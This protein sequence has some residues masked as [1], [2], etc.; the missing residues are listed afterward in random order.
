[1]PLPDDFLAFLRSES[2]SD[3]FPPEWE[4]GKRLPR[5]ETP[6]WQIIV[7]YFKMKIATAE[8][9]GQTHYQGRMPFSLYFRTKSAFQRKLTRSLQKPSRNAAGAMLLLATAAA[10]TAAEAPTQLRCRYQEEFYPDIQTG[11]YP[12]KQWS[13]NSYRV[14][15]GTLIPYSK[16]AKCKKRAAAHIPKKGDGILK[17][18]LANQ[19]HVVPVVVTAE[20]IMQKATE[21]AKL[22]LGI[23]K[24]EPD[25]CHHGLDS[26]QPGLTEA[27][28]NAKKDF[29][30]KGKGAFL[31]H[32]SVEETLPLPKRL[33]GDNVC[34][35]ID[36]GGSPRRIRITSAGLRIDVNRKFLAASESTAVDDLAAA[37]FPLMAEKMPAASG[38]E[39]FCEEYRK[40][41]KANATAIKT[42]R[43]AFRQAFHTDT[44]R[45]DPPHHHHSLRSSLTCASAQE[46]GPQCT[47]CCG[48]GF[49]DHYP[50]EQPGTY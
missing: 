8:A 9:L 20:E 14:R 31:D 42:E 12:P 50:Q 15:S 38:F 47:S 46:R 23:E 40:Y 10:V 13:E 27:V 16:S 6:Q 45:S 2:V 19:E 29:E 21:W 18:P 1:M 33:K 3:L 17:Y 41:H 48:C 5:D 32:T 43:N 44:R 35:V 28:A 26:V 22:G 24:W 37:I 49:R 39:A 4:K 7:K 34:S 30:T 36:P 11:A 25:L